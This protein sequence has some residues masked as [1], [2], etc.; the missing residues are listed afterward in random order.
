MAISH[1]L[2]RAT[3]VTAALFLAAATFQVAPA[4]AN[5]VFDRWEILT[6]H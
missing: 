5:I 2:S 1:L 6:R 3:G 4:R